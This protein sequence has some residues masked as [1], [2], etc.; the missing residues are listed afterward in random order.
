MTFGLE[1]AALAALPFAAALGLGAGLAAFDVATRR[2]LGWGLAILMAIGLV[3]LLFLSLTQ[4]WTTDF[5]TEILGLAPVTALMG[6]F[7]GYGLGHV[8]KT[9]RPS[10]Q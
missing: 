3:G 8:A 6:L 2:S 5:R 7:I 1:V 9:P 10:R 4:T